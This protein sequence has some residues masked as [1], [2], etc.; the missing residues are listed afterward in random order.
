MIQKFVQSLLISKTKD[1]KFA[2]YAFRIFI[3]MSNRDQCRV[4]L[5][6]NGSSVKQKVSALC[7]LMTKDWNLAGTDPTKGPFFK[8]FALLA[9]LPHRQKQI[10]QPCRRRHLHLRSWA[11][12]N[13]LAVFGQCWH[14]TALHA[15][16]IPVWYFYKG[17]A[18]LSAQGEQCGNGV[19]RRHQRRADEE[20]IRSDR[21]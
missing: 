3:W 20:R 15:T 18:L 13:R 7:I 6:S 5:C 4:M 11:K 1:M 10:C 19:F 17:F 14:Q 12:P 21:C 8:G 9:R 2:V 16:V